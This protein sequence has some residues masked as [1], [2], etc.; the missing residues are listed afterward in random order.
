[1]KYSAEH[2]SCLGTREELK[3]IGGFGKFC[4]I[5]FIIFFTWWQSVMI[6]LAVQFRY[7]SAD[8]FNF[9]C[10]HQAS[11]DM[12]DTI[13]C[14]TTNEVAESLQDVIICMEMLGRRFPLPLYR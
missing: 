5:K 10:G 6:A 7:I 9:I 13:D 12:P 1:M 8:R 14:W 3:P 11:N 2:L 4:L